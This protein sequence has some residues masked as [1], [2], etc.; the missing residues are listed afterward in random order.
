M[1]R[2]DRA[3]MQFAIDGD[4]KAVLE[5]MQNNISASKLV[6]IAEKLPDMAR[7]LWSHFPQ[8]PFKP[9]RLES[10]NI[11][12][13]LGHQSL[14]VASELLPEQGRVGDDSVTVTNRQ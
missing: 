12:R 14:S 4:V 8:E 9:I 11:K 13:I 7:L 2:T 5:F 6:G 10:E 1:S 3:A